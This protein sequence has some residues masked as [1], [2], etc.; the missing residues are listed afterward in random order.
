MDSD[1]ILRFKPG[2][3]VIL[4]EFGV[5]IQDYHGIYSIDEEGVISVEFAKHSEW[6]PMV[7]ERRGKNY[8]LHRKDERNHFEMGNRGGAVQTPDMN[9]FWP[10]KL[11]SSEWTPDPEHEYLYRYLCGCC[12][13][14]SLSEPGYQTC[15]ICFWEDDINNRHRIG[16]EHAPTVDLE[17]D[18]VLVHGN[19]FFMLDAPSIMNEDLTLRQARK[20]FKECGACDPKVVK[21]VM[22][23][24]ERMKYTRGES[25]H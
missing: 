14:L 9:P 2:G 16:S 4:T 21:F 6:P 3:R 24:E 11:V 12:D 7:L 23:K 20:N 13:Y 15:L 5:G 1:S 17:S 19:E 22:S 10:F 25:K 18:E 8:F